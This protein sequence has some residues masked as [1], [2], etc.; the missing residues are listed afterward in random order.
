[1]VDWFVGCEEEKKASSVNEFVT[2]WERGMM[3]LLSEASF[4]PE[5][6]GTE[7]C[8]SS[9]VY[10]WGLFVSAGMSLSPFCSSPSVT[11]QFCMVA[12]F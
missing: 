8:S 3:L 5:V 6:R 2:G 10:F 12:F 7:P 1:M 9:L 4:Q 11:H